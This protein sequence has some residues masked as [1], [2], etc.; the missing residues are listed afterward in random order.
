M[1]T[2]RSWDGLTLYAVSS[3]GTLGVFNFDKEELEGI[4]PRDSQTV[5]LQKFGF[6]SPPLPAGYTHAPA[7]MQPNGHSKAAI[8]GIGVVQLHHLHLPVK[9]R[10]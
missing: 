9:H 3:D 8:N 2:Q 6:I 4:A 7:Q 10:L 1:V 5:Y